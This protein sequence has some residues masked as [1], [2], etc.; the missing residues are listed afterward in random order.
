MEK[1]KVVKVEKNQ[2]QAVNM[3]HDMLVV[4]EVLDEM[5]DKCLTGEGFWYRKGFNKAY[6]MVEKQASCKTLNKAKEEVM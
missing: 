5:S 2:N 6:Y 3:M 1:P 4:K